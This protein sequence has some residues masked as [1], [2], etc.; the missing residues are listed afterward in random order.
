[1]KSLPGKT[2]TRQHV[3]ADLSINF[4]ERQVLLSGHTV[5]RVLF[6][7]G[8]DLAM[9]TY[10]S[11]GEV[12]P[13][14]A[15]FQ[16][17]ATDRLPLLQDGRTI[18]WPVSRRDLKLWLNES[19]PV[20]LIVYDGQKDKAYWLPVQIYFLGHSTTEL[21]AGDTINVQIPTRRRLNRLGIKTIVAHKRDVHERLQRKELSHDET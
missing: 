2:R 7:Y 14:W 16:V 1:M 9:T 12:Q 4:V 18:S 3:L 17:K 8:Y 10:N 13:G 11:L 20:V 19:Y 6:D 15:F 5:H 21:F